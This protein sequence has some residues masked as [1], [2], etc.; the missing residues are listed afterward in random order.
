MPTVT[1]VG[2]TTWGTTLGIVLAR[3]GVQVRLL[4][5]SEG[6][7]AK[8][9]AARENARF[10]PGVRF[11]DALHASASPPQAFDDA[12][13]AL[14]VVPSMTLRD[15]A[16]RYAEHIGPGSIVVSATK[17]LEVGTS[18]RMSQVLEEELR[19]DRQHGVCAL[20]GPNL[21]KEIVAGKPSSTVIASSDKKGATMAQSIINSSVFR[22]YTNDDIV[23]VELC[24]A[25]KNIIA[26]GAGISDGLG[27][28]DN[29]KAAF[30]TRGL[31]EIS[32]L[33]VAA[34]ATPATFAGLAGVGDLI[35]TC[36]SP[37]SR[38]HYVGEQLAQGKSLGEIR[39]AMDNVAEGVDTTRGALSLAGTLGVEMP[40]TGVIYEVLFGGVSATDAVAQLMGRDPRSE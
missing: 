10:V 7:A 35:A 26:L 5:R 6:E 36:S 18:N 12:D 3:E 24:G 27:L 38:N 8:L 11:P 20:S 17:G 39:E 34:G 21:A 31:V 29:A 13:I 16:R 40:I 23:G 19:G 14:F 30:V 22:V 9:E 15:N 28:G 37:F 2:T 25:L 33:G 32:R 4:A 1:I